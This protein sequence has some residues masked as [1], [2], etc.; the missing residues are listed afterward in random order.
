[1]IVLDMGSGMNPWVERLWN[2]SLQILLVTTSQ[3]E[4]V[5]ES[6]AT[7]KSTS[8]GDVDGKLRLVVNQSDDD[9]GCRVAIVLPQIVDNFWG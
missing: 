7:L 6:Y 5:L 2:A 4:A 3:P 9:R 8:W 1:M